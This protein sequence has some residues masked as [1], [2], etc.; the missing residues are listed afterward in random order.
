MNF[1]KQNKQI[2]KSDLTTKEKTTNVVLFFRNSNKQTKIISNDTG[3]IDL[4]V[5][6]NNFDIQFA[7]SWQKGRKAWIFLGNGKNS[8][9]YKSTDGGNSWS[10]VST[11]DSGFPVGDGVG[12]IGLAVYDSQTIYAILDNQDR[13]PSN[14]NSSTSSDLSKNDFELISKEAFLE[15]DNKKLDKFIRDNYFPTEYTSKYVKK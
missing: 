7:S 9:I 6:P 2:Y 14:K 10:L 1:S 11:K 3:I 8:G 15:L 4:D 13:R 5:D 12:R